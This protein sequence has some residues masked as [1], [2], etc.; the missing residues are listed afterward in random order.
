M[1]LIYPDS[2]EWYKTL[3]EFESLLDTS[4][5]ELEIRQYLTKHSW[6]LSLAFGHGEG[7]VFSEYRIGQGM[8][9]DHLVVYG[10][11]LHMQASIIE[12]K[13]PTDTIYTLS[14]GM[15]SASDKAFQQTVS[16]M[17]AINRD[18]YRFLDDLK[19]NIEQVADEKSKSPFQG[20]IHDNF[21]DVVRFED[22]R[23][24]DY[25]PKIVMGRRQTE[26]LK[27][28]EYRTGL[29]YDHGVE[30]VPY[31]RILDAL[32]VPPFTVPEWSWT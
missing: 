20:A 32:R 9:T 21:F 13:K 19:G 10:R 4:P 28:R 7:V 23:R 29:F 27:E 18:P 26:T 6:V 16:R 24:C 11:S 22:I 17:N 1:K 25:T 30:I 2:G 12:L 8:Q 3:K 5:K 14:G 31:D 15:T